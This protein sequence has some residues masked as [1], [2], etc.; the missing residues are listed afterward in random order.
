LGVS[1]EAFDAVISKEQSITDDL[2][3]KN[4][5]LRSLKLSHWLGIE[6]DDEDKVI[7]VSN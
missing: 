4:E 3:R 2:K 6:A 7:A 5:A 1:G